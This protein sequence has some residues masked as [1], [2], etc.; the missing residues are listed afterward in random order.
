MRKSLVSMAAALLAMALM[1]C[2]NGTAPLEP[3][4]VLDSAP[5]Q[6]PLGLRQS[7]DS[8][9]DPV[10]Q[11]DA[12]AEA[13]LG[14]YQ[15][16][17]YSPDPSRDNAYVLAATVDAS[18]TSWKLP[19]VDQSVETWVRMRAL[20][21]TGNRSAESASIHVVLNPRPGGIDAPSDDPHPVR[22]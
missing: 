19:V 5:P 10:L 15:I 9:S 1:G 18:T 13:D 3:L 20:D 11:W 14:G 21:G 16:Y 7:L 6:A 17:M 2:G 8:V 12:N 4:A 22:P